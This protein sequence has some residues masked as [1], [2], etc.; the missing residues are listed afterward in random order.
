MSVDYAT[1][2]IALID[3]KYSVFHA[4][5][6]DRNN[7]PTV[8]VQYDLRSLQLHHHYSLYLNKF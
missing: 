1:V 4:H 7:H 8:H 5:Y 3:L 2:K 6:E